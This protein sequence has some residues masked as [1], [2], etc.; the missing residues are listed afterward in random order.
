MEDEPAGARVRD[1]LVHL[2][3]L[4]RVA[5]RLTGRGGD[6]EDLVQE[7]YLRAFRGAG[8]FTPG[9]DLRAW[10][11]RLLRNAFIDGWRR[12]SRSPVDRRADP[13]EAASSSTEG[14]NMLRGDVELERLR[15]VVGE[16][17]EAALRALP[18][19]SRTVVLLDLEGLA[20][21]E[22]AEVMGCAPGTVKSRLY[23]ARL[24]LRERLAEYGP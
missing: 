10:L 3:A 11:F 20:E 1:A 21:A 18:E 24:A 23:R 2:D 16:E 7:T 4:H 19:E 13:E 6:A 15:G 5:R 22:I 12:E 14:Q 8:R 9:T 17:I